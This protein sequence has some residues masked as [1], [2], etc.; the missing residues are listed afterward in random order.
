MQL[1]YR[2]NSFMG[3][4]IV[5]EVSADNQMDQISNFL[6]TEQKNWVKS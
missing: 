3:E 4:K 1:F 6:K 2:R 5:Y